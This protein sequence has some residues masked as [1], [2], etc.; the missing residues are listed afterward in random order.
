[1]LSLK[2]PKMHIIK[3]ANA[4]ALH[5]SL[6]RNQ[7]ARPPSLKCSLFLIINF[8]VLSINKTQNVMNLLPGT[9]NY[10]EKKICFKTVA[11]VRSRHKKNDIYVLKYIIIIMFLSIYINEIRHLYFKT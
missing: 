4:S 3:P 7:P 9:N 8:P 5:W 10:T 6:P 11:Y 2:T 1:M